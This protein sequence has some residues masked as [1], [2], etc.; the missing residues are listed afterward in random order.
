[1]KA[2][3]LT[4]AAAL[5]LAVAPAAA[6][7]GPLHHV[8][9]SV[10]KG[11][12]NGGTLVGGRRWSNTKWARQRTGR[13]GSWGIPQMIQL[14]QSSAHKVAQR[15]PRSV[16]MIGDISAK[17]GG[18]LPGHNS[19]QSGRDA[20]VGFYMHDASKR[21][22]V[23]DAFLAFDAQGN[24]VGDK[25]LHFDDARNWELVATWLGDGR[26]EVRGIF[27][28]GWL[29]AR[30]LKRA[31]EV[32]APKTLIERAQMVMMQP[33]NAEP[34]HDHFHLRI[35]CPPS[36]KGV[37]FDDSIDRTPHAPSGISAPSGDGG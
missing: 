9:G 21:P 16:L 12:P 3:R 19:H 18:P 4:L 29:K 26:V 8:A 37:C 25:R 13:A 28:A 11:F 27:I 36:Q 6:L 20:D 35:A 1:M 24:A 30:L 10:S 33:P 7:A 22:V 17:N 32:H 34:H 2:G 15:F 5:A 14:L 31:E 23:S